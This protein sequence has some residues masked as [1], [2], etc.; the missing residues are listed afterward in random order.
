LPRTYFNPT[1]N[2]AMGWSIPAALGA[3]RVHPGRQTITITGDGCL[4]MSAM[5][6]STAAREGLPVKFFILDD[7]AYAFMQKLQQ[8][9]YHRTTA[10]ILARL[11]YGALAKALGVAYQEISRGDQ[12]EP[13]IRGALEE[14]GPVLTRVISD[15][16]KRPIRWIEAVKDRFK[17]ELSPEQKVRFAARLGVRSLERPTKND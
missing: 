14:T 12:L 13:C 6:I 3:Q 2:Q 11:D 17:K 9:A 15:Y 1:D 5:E 16:G 10:T 8:P 4:L 7:Q